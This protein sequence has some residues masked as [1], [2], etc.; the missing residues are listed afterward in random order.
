M[1]VGAR[2]GY[3]TLF[4]SVG[5]R[6]SEFGSDMPQIEPVYFASDHAKYQLR[7]QEQFGKMTYYVYLSVDD[8]GIWRVQSF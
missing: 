7:R 6:I 1:F 5:V 8:D 2:D 4:N 3:A